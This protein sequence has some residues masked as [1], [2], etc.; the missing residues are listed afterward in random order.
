MREIRDPDVLAKIQVRDDMSMIDVIRRMNE[1]SMQILVV[2]DSEKSVV[3]VITEKLRKKILL[4]LLEKGGEI[5]FLT[6]MFI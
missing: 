4:K 5:Y 1:T 3:G 2:I 6:M